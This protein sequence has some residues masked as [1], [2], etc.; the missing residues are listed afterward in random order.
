MINIWVCVELENEDV[1]Y[2]RGAYDSLEQAKEAADKMPK[3][4]EIILVETSYFPTLQ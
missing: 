3:T 4:S 1:L 2:V